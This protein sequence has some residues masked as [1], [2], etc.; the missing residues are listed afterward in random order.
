M[1]DV[2]GLSKRMSCSFKRFGDFSSELISALS[3]GI[4]SINVRLNH[5]NLAS[6]RWVRELSLGWTYSRVVDLLKYLLGIL[7]RHIA[8]FLDSS[9]HWKT[10]WL[11]HSLLH[12]P[13]FHNDIS[14][15]VR[16]GSLKSGERLGWRC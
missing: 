8:L 9:R 4:Q 2:L 3:A 15:K 5:I 14:E 11:I 16:M 10:S 12:T 7:C 13:R 1:Q 6:R